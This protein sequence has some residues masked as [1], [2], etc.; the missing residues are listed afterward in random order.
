[1]S[2]RIFGT[3]FK[4]LARM[5]PPTA[6]RKP[7]AT[8]FLNASAAPLETLRDKFD[9]FRSEKET[10]MSYN[11]QACYLRKMLNDKFDLFS[12]RIRI[13]QNQNAAHLFVCRQEEEQP[14]TLG[15]VSLNRRDAIEYDS[16]FVVNVPQP[17]RPADSAMRAAL[18][19]YKLATRNY[20]IKYF[21]P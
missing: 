17:L 11:S 8:A 3:D 1:M 18:N 10:R 14:V 13:E 2:N 9:L 19:R 15:R 20:I 12:R 5:L 21:Q 16:A 4:K 7:V 6:L